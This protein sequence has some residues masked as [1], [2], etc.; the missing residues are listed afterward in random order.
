MENVWKRYQYT[1]IYKP[2]PQAN[3][4]GTKSFSFSEGDEATKLLGPTSIE[5]RFHCVQYLLLKP[6]CRNIRTP[7]LLV[8]IVRAQVA[9]CS[10]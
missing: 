1:E 9:A 10:V 2:R 4:L 8:A 7:A 6:Q 3:L 5:L